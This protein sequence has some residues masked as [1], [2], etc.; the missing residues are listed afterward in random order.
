VVQAA[1][2]EQCDDGNLVGGDGCSAT[3]KTDVTVP[4]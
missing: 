2:G 3:C 4:K 1:E